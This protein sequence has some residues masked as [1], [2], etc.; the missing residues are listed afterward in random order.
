MIFIA[1]AP[2]TLKYNSQR[3]SKAERFVTDGVLLAPML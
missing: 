1:S 2:N 3:L